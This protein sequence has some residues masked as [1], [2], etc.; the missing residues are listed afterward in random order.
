MDIDAAVVTPER[1]AERRLRQRALV[2]HMPCLSRE[3]FEQAE[4]GTGERERALVQRC[5]TAAWPERERT[6]RQ[7]A[8][9]GRCVRLQR[10]STQN[11]SQPGRQLARR[12]GFRHVVVGPEFEAFRVSMPSMPGIMTSS[13]TMSKSPASARCAPCSP[14]GAVSASKPSRLRYSASSEESSRSSSTSRTLGIFGTGVDAPMIAPS[15]PA[16]R[17]AQTDFT[18]V[19]TPRTEVYAGAAQDAIVASAATSAAPEPGPGR[20]R[21]PSLFNRQENRS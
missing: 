17:R 13:T 10:A 2:H 8:V 6:D 3:R 5:A 4:L 15:L 16:A 18:I 19:Y 21:C 7:G 20:C 14:S 11:G 1:P 9:R 12:A